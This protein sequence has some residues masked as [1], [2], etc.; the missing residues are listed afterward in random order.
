MTPDARLTEW[1]TELGLALPPAPA[2][3]GVY[4]PLLV[5]GGLVYASGHLPVRPDGQ[6]VTG[7]VGAELD[8]A[9]GCA[10]ARWAALG[11]LASLRKEFGTLDRIGR[12]LKLFGVVSATPE[13]T[14]HAAVI[15]GAS[16]LLA[17]VFGPK[18][19]VGARSAVGAASLPL[20]AAV[21]IEAVFEI[22]LA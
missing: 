7:R 21:E 1:L 8:V 6:V 3:K 19:G 18:A 4:R 15:N 12:L 11:I 13:F 22:E 5:A 2:P 17:H 10:A 9:A 14:Q 20:G 16:E